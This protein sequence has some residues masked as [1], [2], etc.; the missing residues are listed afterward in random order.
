M[1]LLSDPTAGQTQLGGLK[2]AY[3]KCGSEREG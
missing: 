3:D 1:Q 2:V